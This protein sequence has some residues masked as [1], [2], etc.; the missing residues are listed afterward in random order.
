MGREHSRGRVEGKEHLHVRLGEGEPLLVHLLHVMA[1][2]LLVGKAGCR[3]IRLVCHPGAF[4]KLVEGR[5]HLLLRLC[6][7]GGT[8]TSRHRSVD[9]DIVLL[10]SVDDLLDAPLNRL[11]PLPQL[12]IG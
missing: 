9:Q 10:T 5:L 1:K 3:S 12:V 6:A 2:G 8:E 4:Q 7:V 11:V